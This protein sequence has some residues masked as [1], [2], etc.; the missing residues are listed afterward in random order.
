MK[1]LYKTLLVTLLVPLWVNAQ[2][3][4][5]PSGSFTLEQSINYALENAINI[6]NSLIDEKISD[7][8]VKETRGIGLPQID[9]SVTL[10]HNAKLQRFYTAYDPDG[11]SIGG[12]LGSVPGIQPGD[13][14]GAQNFFQ[15]PSNGTAALS[16]NQILFNNS[17][18]LGLKASRTYR[19]LATKTTQQTK[20]QIIEGVTKAY[21]AAVI[22]TERIKLFESNIAR[23]DS[24]F[25]S[26]KALNEN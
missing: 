8:L 6:Q 19:D 11:F 16:I 5:V 24:L 22:N 10:M 18:L 3:T 17:Y 20:E 4:D 9:G 7:A 13:V 12:D 21:F 26:T 14:V 15:L 1:R 23:V 2:T 25:K